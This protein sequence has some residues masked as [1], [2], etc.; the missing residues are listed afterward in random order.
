MYPKLGARPLIRWSIMLI[1]SLIFATLPA[2]PVH[3]GPGG[4]VN[5]SGSLWFDQCGAPNSDLMQ[6][7]WNNSPYRNVGI[8]IGGINVGS[9]TTNLSAAWVNKV[10]SQGWSFV[11]TYVGR[12]APCS[13]Y[14]NKISSTISTAQQQARDAV[15]DAESKASTYGFTVGTIIYLDIE[16]YDTS[17]T[18]CRNAV[19]AYVAEWSR[20][21]RT[22][23]YRVGAYGSSCASAIND[24]AASN[25]P[26][27]VWIA[28]YNLQ[29]GVYN[30]GCVNSG[31]WTQSQRHHQYSANSTEAWGGQSLTI[32]RSCAEG[33]VAGPG[34]NDGIPNNC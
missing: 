24:W 31:Y 32:D 11:P 5:I 28:D 29:H 1:M 23:H 3:A 33:H 34:N 16:G 4:T 7:W 9:C 30:V 26:D 20:Q 8:Y 22:D 25:P 15:A 10:G 14:A 19:N 6:T 13:N 17:N 21:L 12:Q 2:I 18:S 27:D